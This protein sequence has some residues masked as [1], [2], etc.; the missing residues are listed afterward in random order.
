MLKIVKSW[1]LF[2]LLV[3]IHIGLLTLFQF[4]AWPEMIAYPW[5]MSK[6]FSMYRDIIHP[7]PPLAL[8]ML[9]GWYAFTG[10]SLSSLQLFTYLVT[11]IT[12]GL[13]FGIVRQ[14]HGAVYAGIAVSIFALLHILFEGNGIWFDALSIPFLLLAYRET[15]YKKRLLWGG[16]FLGL[17]IL[18]KQTNA[19]FAVLYLAPYIFRRHIFFKLTAAILVPVGII[20]FAFSFFPWFA[21]F[22]Y[23][24]V[25]H[26]LFVHARL[27]GFILKPTPRQLLELGFLLSPLVFVWRFDKRIFFLTVVS[28]VFAIPRFAL[29]HLLPAAAFLSIGMTY[30]L[31]KKPKMLWFG[32][33]YILCVGAL[34]VKTIQKNWQKPIRFFESDVLDTRAQLSAYLPHNEPVFFYNVPAQYFVMTPLLPTKPWADTFPWYLEVPGM[35]AQI[36]NSLASVNYVVSGDFQIG[37]T[38]ALGAYRPK[39]IDAYIQN[40]FV[41]WQNVSS[42]FTILIRKSSSAVLQ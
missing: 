39:I 41:S 3:C 38:Y 9:Y 8:F 6:G 29:F 12:D 10:F 19:V 30:L 7:Y 25:F 27:P 31:A 2:I 17:A 21:D 23:W 28:L 20:I 40:Q 35:Q 15:F 26:P 42:G 1:W 33:L 11:L 36:I 13:I 34:S 14:K 16:V 5:L 32:V 37:D 4:T 22:W 24:A 18:I